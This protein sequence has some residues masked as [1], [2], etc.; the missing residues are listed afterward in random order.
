MISG[1]RG[2]FALFACEAS[3]LLQR[4]M[5]NHFVFGRLGVAAHW[6]VATWTYSMSI[7]GVTV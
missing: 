4:E 6:M 5:E 2:I 7:S 1:V 3:V